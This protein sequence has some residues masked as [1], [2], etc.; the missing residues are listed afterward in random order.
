MGF[1]NKLGVAKTGLL[2]SMLRALI[3]VGSVLSAGKED[4][5]AYQKLGGRYKLET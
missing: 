4:M 1:V 2:G 3:A 5:E